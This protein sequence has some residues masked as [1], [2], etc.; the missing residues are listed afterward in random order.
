MST[1][2]KHVSFAK[3]PKRLEPPNLVEVQTRS[4]ASF[5][6][7]DLPRTKRA[8]IGLQ[9]AFLETFPIESADKQYRLEFVHYLLGKPKYAVTE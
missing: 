2:V 1:M 3:L 7:Q 9:A 6:Q 5:L 4:Y 8:N